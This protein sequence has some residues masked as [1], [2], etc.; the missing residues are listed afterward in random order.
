MWIIATGTRLAWVET[1]WENDDEKHRSTFMVRN[2]MKELGAHAYSFITERGW[3]LS[4]KI[5]P[6]NSSKL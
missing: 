1:P 4:I 2:M 3:R 6:R 5:S